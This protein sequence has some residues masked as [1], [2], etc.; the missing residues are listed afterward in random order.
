MFLLYWWKQLRSSP[1]KL[2]FLMFISHGLVV[3]NPCTVLDLQDDYFFIGYT[4]CP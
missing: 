4:L 1:S 2:S 3:S